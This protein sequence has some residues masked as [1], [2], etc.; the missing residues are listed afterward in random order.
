MLFRSYKAFA[1]NIVVLPGTYAWTGV[2]NATTG[3]TDSFGRE[4]STPQAAAS[5]F[6]VK[7]ASYPAD[8]LRLNA[9]REAQAK[10]M[11]ID[12]NITQLRRERQRNGIDDAEFEQ[13]IAR[14]VAKKNQVRDDHQRRVGGG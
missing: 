10:I 14:Q 11:E 4:Q 6:G 12:R 1:P 2:S 13:K 5:A 3:R 9:Q 7:L 8:V